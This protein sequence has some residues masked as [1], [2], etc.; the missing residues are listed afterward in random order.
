MNQRNL[1]NNKQ[2][3]TGLDQNIAGLLC[4]LLGAVTGIIFLILEKNNRF[5]KFHAMQSLLVFGGLFVLNIVLGFIP[6]LGWILS[7]VIYPIGVIL[8]IVLMVKA[9]SGKWFKLPIVGDIAEKQV[10]RM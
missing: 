7:V 8:W 9:Y 5:I 6:I 1:N 4:Y 2:S 3:S 10:N